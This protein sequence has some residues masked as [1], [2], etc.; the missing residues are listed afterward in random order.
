MA[1][2]RDVDRNYESDLAR[3]A[4]T[5]LVVQ[6]C[7]GGRPINRGYICAHCGMDT[8]HGDCDGV[9]GFVKAAA[10]K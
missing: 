1:K 2:I 5:Y 8:S 4:Q 3:L 7:P 10:S 9:Q 6:A